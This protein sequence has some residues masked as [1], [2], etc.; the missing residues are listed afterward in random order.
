MKND[1]LKNS[2]DSLESISKLENTTNEPVQ[3]RAALPS[4]PDGAKVQSSSGSGA[5][6]TFQVVS[7]N[8]MGTSIAPYWDAVKDTGHFTPYPFFSAT[9]N[10]GIPQ[11]TIWSLKTASG[12]TV[13]TGSVGTKP[14]TLLKFVLGN[15]S[16]GQPSFTGSDTYTLT[17]SNSVLGSLGGLDLVSTGGGLVI[18][19]NID[20]SEEYYEDDP[21]KAVKSNAIMHQ[22]RYLSSEEG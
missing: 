17:F 8:I 3:A 16:N 4:Y 1:S 5:N 11:G 6:Y 19:A 2:Q 14:P 15:L 13:A 9:F 21:L 12:I 18:I 20:G 10:S 7:M 22:E